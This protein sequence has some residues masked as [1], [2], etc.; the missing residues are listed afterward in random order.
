MQW[1][2]DG[3]QFS[4]YAISFEE[5]RCLNLF[6][7][8][9]TCLNSFMKVSINK[10]L[11]FEKFLLKKQSVCHWI[12]VLLQQNR[13]NSAFSFDIVLISSSN[14][15]LISGLISCCKVWI[16]NFPPLVEYSVT[17]WLICS[18]HWIS[19][20]QKKP[21]KSVYLN[22]SRCSKFDFSIPTSLISFIKISMKRLQRFL[23]NPNKQ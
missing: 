15:R 17:K 22:I 21:K 18:L 4:A 8:N 11:L 23:E 1:K 13:E 12:G 20:S 10:S 14:I 6:F 5:R 7:F 19:N 3:A 2:L 9:S 16:W